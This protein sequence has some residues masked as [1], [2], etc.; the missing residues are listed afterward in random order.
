M[1]SLYC[2]KVTDG[3]KKVNDML[4]GGGGGNHKKLQEV[5]SELN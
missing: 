1:K 3:L 5:L 4:G 2:N